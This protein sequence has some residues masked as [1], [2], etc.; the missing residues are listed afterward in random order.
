MSHAEDNLD[1][2]AC[3][4]TFDIPGFREAKPEAE[5]EEEFEQEEFAMQDI[6]ELDQ[7]Y[8][9]EELNVL[10]SMRNQMLDNDD[11]RYDY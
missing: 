2:W 4:Y 6:D 11:G 7:N 9:D 1:S 8:F 10:S 5:T 3:C